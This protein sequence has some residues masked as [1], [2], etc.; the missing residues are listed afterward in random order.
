MPTKCFRIVLQHPVQMANSKTLLDATEVYQYTKRTLYVKVEES[1]GT[2]KA[3]AKYTLNAYNYAKEGGKNYESMRICPCNGTGQT[4]GEDKCFCRYES[5]YVPF[6]SS[7]AGA[8][9]KN[10]LFFTIR[11]IIRQAQRIH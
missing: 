9:L 2:V 1:G 10:I 6:Y 11:I 3:S 5:A 7:E 4:T 8:E